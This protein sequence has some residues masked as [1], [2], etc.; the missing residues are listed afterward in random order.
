[1]VITK[2]FVA[3]YQISLFIME[4]ISKS[5]LLLCSVGD[6]VKN[7]GWNNYK[8]QTLKKWFSKYGARAPYYGVC[9]IESKKHFF[10]FRN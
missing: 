6:G 5:F 4:C 10:L 8:F 3:N 7:Y 1:M 9:P 2:E